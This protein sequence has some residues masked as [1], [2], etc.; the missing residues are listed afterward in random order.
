M[1]A[2]NGNTR[3]STAR[4]P[5]IHEATIAVVLVAIEFYPIPVTCAR[6]FLLRFGSVWPKNCVQSKVPAHLYF[7]L[8][9]IRRRRRREKEKSGSSKS[10]HAIPS[11]ITYIY[12]NRHVKMPQ[13][14]CIHCVNFY[15]H[16]FFFQSL[17]V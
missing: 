9:R 2:F 6:V 13:T 11:Y 14:K 3:I 12:A 5:N 17:P 8:N 4:I 10:I 15:L 16:V 1:N 7:H